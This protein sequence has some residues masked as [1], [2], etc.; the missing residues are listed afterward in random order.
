MTKTKPTL[1]LIFLILVLLVSAC[2]QQ[3]PAATLSPLNTEASATEETV[4]AVVTEPVVPT[5]P[6]KVLVSSD[7][8]FW[9]GVGSGHN[10]TLAER[11]TAFTQS[12]NLTFEKHESITAEQV[13]PSVKILVTTADAAQIESMNQQL[14]DLKILAVDVS[15]LT[16][17]LLNVHAI[18]SEGGTAEQ[19]A[20][21]AGYA[22]ALTTPD[23]RVGVLTLGSDDLG[24]RTR[25][26]FV[27]GV[28]YYCGLC[29]PQ[30]PPFVSQPYYPFTAE[31][32][33]PAD[34]NSWQT[35]ADSL[36]GLGVTAIFVQ[37]E[38]SSPDLMTY[39][40]SRSITVIGVEGQAGLEVAGRV[41]GVLGSD[42]YTSVETAVSGLLAG[43]D[44]GA[45]TG[46]LELKQVN[47][48]LMSDGK[49]ILFERIREE[50]LNGLIKDR[51]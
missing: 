1:M 41:V 19:R 29:K 23:Y 46:S 25:D 11:L 2:N 24:N 42:L 47:P 49:R 4:V 39:L 28:R 43:E 8:V 7:I 27:V 33:N 21:L 22:L 16:P 12:N 34:P 35:A 10:E 14:P 50:L 37:P 26:S 40:A 17:G 20:F 30:Y 36:L 38:I 15:G 5:E 13:T 45:S 6:A 31:V 48:E 44:I 32:P 9:A 18:N 3:Q 51:P